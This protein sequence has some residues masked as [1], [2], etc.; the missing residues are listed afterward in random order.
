MGKPRGGRPIADQRTLGTLF[1][2]RVLGNENAVWAWC[3]GD[4]CNRAAGPVHDSQLGD[5]VLCAVAAGC[6]LNPIDL[7]HPYGMIGEAVVKER[8]LPRD[9]SDAD[10]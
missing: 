2:I 4:R 7:G 1:A 8:T 9:V 10:K 3:R 6:P 5:V